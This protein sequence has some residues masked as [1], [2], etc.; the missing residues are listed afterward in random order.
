MTAEVAVMNAQGLAMAADS[1]VTI[2]RGDVRD[3]KI[4]TS[5]N[6]IFALSKYQPIAIM[7]YGNAALLDVPWETI[8]KSYRKQLGSTSFEHVEDYA[9][10]FA[11]YVGGSEWLF[12]S[13][14]QERYVRDYVG[15]IFA[16]I[17]N[18]VEDTV[19]QK[20]EANGSIDDTAVTAVIA[21]S[22]DNIWQRVENQPVLPLARGDREE[23]VR[24]LYAKTIAALMRDVFEAAPIAPEDRHRLG[25]L[26]VV[27][28]TRTPP[29]QLEHLT[30]VVVAGFGSN[31]LFPS[32]R[33]L[34]V[35][36]VAAGE[37]VA[38]D[39]SHSAIDRD[40]SNAS[41]RAFAQTEMV[42]RFMEGVDPN[43]QRMLELSVA[44][45]LHGY[46]EAMLK[47]LPRDGMAAL[48]KE[49]AEAQ[50]EMVSTL[51]DE[52]ATHRDRA[53]VDGVISAVRVLPLGELAHMA[54]S[55][56]NLTS[57]KRRVSMETESV[58]GPIDVAVISRGDGFIWIKR[59]HYFDLDR[60][61]HFQANY[62]RED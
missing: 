21:S 57:F 56:V 16:A 40:G 24:K 62:Y 41:V 17:K 30:G 53:Y 42:A 36:G 61:L 3:S 13:S 4:F 45:I 50:A 32:Y 27:L 58:A 51:S 55:L 22:V 18:D 5:A 47:K 31:D 39:G 23:R 52:L 15:G 11:G 8:I 37:L 26:G 14:V 49:L 29:W 60:N 6:K 1:A 10:D 25:E 48:R 28:L 59:K 46:T 2:A 20:I 54:E 12:P 34:I 9:S 35:D 38:W 19:R 7:I 43:Y 33:E 44:R